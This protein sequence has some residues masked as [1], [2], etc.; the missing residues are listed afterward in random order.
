MERSRSL[1]IGVYPNCGNPFRIEDG[2][3]GEGWTYCGEANRL[4]SGKAEKI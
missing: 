2:K 4:K 1:M 3:G